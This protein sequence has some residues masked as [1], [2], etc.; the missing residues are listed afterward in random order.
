MLYEVLKALH[1]IAVI[2]WMAGLLY[3]PRLF[4]YHAGVEPG[5]AQSEL[6]K[7]MERR[8]LR[9]IMNPAMAMVW[10]F[11]LLL[12]WKGEW[13]STGWWQAKM[14][15]VVVLTGVN[16]IYAR[17]HRDFAAD[18]NTHPA[19]FYRYWNEVP[20]LL[21]IAI[22]FLAVLKPAFAQTAEAEGTGF[23][24][25]RLAHITSWYQAQID[26][27]A[28]PGAVIALARDGKTAYL[29]AIGTY[30]RA[31]KKPLKP[32]AI[33]WIASMT[34]PVTSV[35][36]MMLV[37]EGKLDLEAPVAKYLP[38]LADMKVGIER[39]DP[40][41]DKHSVTTVPPKRPMQ[42]IDLLRHTSGL[43]YPEEGNDGLH[44][45]YNLI[46]FGRQRTLADLTKSLGWMPLLHQPGEVW[47]YSLGVDV[48]ARVIEVVSGLGFDQFLQQRI[49][50]PLRMVDTGFVVP[51]EKLYRLVDPI[52]GGRYPLWDVT[53]PGTLF[54]G[55]GGL[56]STAPDYLRFCQMLL[57][58]GTLDGV[59]LL[60]AAT[61][62]RMATPALPDSVTFAGDQGQWVGPKMGSSWGL[63]FNIRTNPDF[64]LVPGAVG[65]FKWSGIWGTDFWID[66]VEK[67][68]V[69]QMIQVPPS[70]NHGQYRNGLRLLSYA[71]LAGPKQI[72]AQ[73]AMAID[74][75]TLATYAGL[76]D[77]GASLSAHDKQGAVPPY[78]GTGLPL[79]IENGVL[80]AD[81]PYEGLPAARAG[82]AKGDTITKI[83]GHETK[84]LSMEEAVRLMRGASGSEV[85]LDVK[86]PSDDKRLSLT[87]M[88]QPIQA[89]GVRLRLTLDGKALAAQAAGRLPVLDF[90]NGRPA[91]LRALSTTEF[92]SGTTLLKFL[93]DGSGKATQLILNPGDE[94]IEA[95]RVD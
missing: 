29:Q 39:V 85:H 56:V 53:K 72:I 46:D 14:F 58:G 47:E 12:A 52:D 8:L 19:R 2:A 78:I 3:L 23:V 4:V 6:F 32:D 27:K 28:F 42:V 66:P 13:W 9:G 73:R 15:L 48:L 38:E 65:T 22:V 79:V 70:K 62:K 76:Y 5:S 18:R 84:G 81:T 40:Q 37:D 30:D 82:I 55:G 87:L 86:R 69:V 57:N 88:R 24:P 74:E 49:F 21:M 95:R 16:Q 17:W 41:T 89:P 68:V 45:V 10:L 26:D 33:F 59:R 1:I 90:E 61:V 75:A 20:T 67:L 35:A 34:K 50:A 36:A 63:G 31:G 44:R 92:A 77:F 91:P 80:V 25:Q 7:T 11:G 83:D 51:P 60:Q 54:S 93:T 43:T 71:A 94:Q 64:S